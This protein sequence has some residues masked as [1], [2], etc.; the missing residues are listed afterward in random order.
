MKPNA[1]S[2]IPQ[3]AFTLIE[4]LVV[5]A[6]IAILAAMLLPALNSAK[7]R[8]QMTTDLN[9]NKQLMLGT[10]MYSG[11]QN[12]YLPGAGWGTADPCWA[13]AAGIPTGPVASLAQ[14]TIVRSNQVEFCKRGQLFPYIRS[15]KIFLCPADNVYNNNFF[16]C[17]I[18]FTSYVWNGSVCGYGNIQPKSYRITQFKPLSIIQWEADR[19]TPFWFNDV[20]SFP[21]EGISGRHGKG[22]TVGEVGG[23]TERISLALYYTSRYAGAVGARGAG[24]PLQLLPNQMWCNPGKTYG[25]MNQ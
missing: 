22:A 2:R 7:N 19:D 13:H 11:D 21:D 12:D 23:S 4:L 17:N 20:S 24:I 25:L 6:I 9:N 3:P 10:I 8:A 16:Q 15:E 18:Y 14:M 1:N 5:I